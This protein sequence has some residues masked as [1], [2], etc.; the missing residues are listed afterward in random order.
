M[1]KR[2]AGTYEVICNRFGH[3]ELCKHSDTLVIAQDIADKD[4]PRTAFLG[5]S[6]DFDY[7]KRQWSNL[8]NNAYTQGNMHCIFPNIFFNSKLLGESE[9][10]EL[11]HFQG[12]QFG[13]RDSKKH[14]C[15]LSLQIDLDHPKVWMLGILRRGNALPQNRQVYLYIGPDYELPHFDKKITWKDMLEN[16]IEEIGSSTI[17]PIVRTLF[18]ADGTINL[19]QMQLLNNN[20]HLGKFLDP[21]NL[22]TIYH[23]PQNTLIALNTQGINGC[24]AYLENWRS[25]LPHNNAETQ[26]IKNLSA[27][28]KADINN[29]ALYILEYLMQT[30]EITTANSATSCLLSA[31]VSD[32]LLRSALD[33]LE[34]CVDDLNNSKKARETC[35][36]KITQTIKKLHQEP[37]PDYDSDNQ[38]IAYGY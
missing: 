38:P 17:A 34:F 19:L 33:I 20:L 2:L 22:I 9:A 35:L 6:V 7:F 18:K 32:D 31:I 30:R 4:L 23:N 27:H 5:N 24:S 11:L 29:T 37:E 3:A 15:G 21:L 14:L 36:I 10:P 1:L 13:Y 8:T 12:L 16:L 26:K 25:A 28:L